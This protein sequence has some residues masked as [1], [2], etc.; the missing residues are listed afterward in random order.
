MTTYLKDGGRQSNLLKVIT[1][2][3]NKRSNYSAVNIQFVILL[4]K[5]LELGLTCASPFFCCKSLT[6]T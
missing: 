2:K 5:Y 3:P 4:L 1:K 6:N